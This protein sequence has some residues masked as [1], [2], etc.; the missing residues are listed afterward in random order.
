MSEWGCSA[1]NDVRF[2]SNHFIMSN[3][4]SAFLKLHNIDMPVTKFK[5]L[6]RNS[7]CEFTVLAGSFRINVKKVK[8]YDINKFKKIEVQSEG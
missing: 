7:N 3:I 8:V 6:V 4:N 1:N 5:E 2:K